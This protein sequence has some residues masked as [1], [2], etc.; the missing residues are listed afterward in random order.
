MDVKEVSQ[1]GKLVNIRTH[2]CFS[3]HRE[4]LLLILKIYIVKPFNTPE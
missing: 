4:K 1:A 3:V 2:V